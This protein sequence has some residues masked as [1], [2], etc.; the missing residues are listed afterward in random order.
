VVADLDFGNAL[1]MLGDGTGHFSNSTPLSTNNHLVRGIV[2]GDF[3]GDG[4]NDLAMT[5]GRELGYVHVFLGNGDG[6]FQQGKKFTTG[7]QYPT[8]VLAGDFNGDG[9]MDLAV[10]NSAAG[11]SNGSVAVLLGHGNGRFD[12]PLLYKFPRLENHQRTDL[13]DPDAIATGNFTSDKRLDVAVAFHDG[14]V[15]DPGYVFVFLG[16]GD[17]T[18]K[19]GV[20]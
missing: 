9:K 8:G 11:V 7:G 18:F 19:E 16:N 15:D 4:N 12:P 17:G 10:L 2:V 3:N 5:D 14:T 6:T 20:R 13:Y 1:A